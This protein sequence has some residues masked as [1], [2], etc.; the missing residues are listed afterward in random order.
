[1]SAIP[2]FIYKRSNQIAMIIFVPI[3]A[4]L[5]ITIYLYIHRLAVV[6]AEHAHKTGAS[7][8]VAVISHQNRERFHA[9]QLYKF[10]DILK[11]AEPN[12]E[13]PH[14]IPSDAVQ[15]FIFRV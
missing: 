11:R 1:M 10:L 4:L 8:L 5:F 9:S 7:H 14:K 3:F 12:R 15:S 13:F 2:S 6:Q